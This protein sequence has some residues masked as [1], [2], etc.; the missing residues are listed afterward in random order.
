MFDSIIFETALFN[1]VSNTILFCETLQDLVILREGHGIREERHQ[2]DLLQRIV[3]G[4]DHNLMPAEE[5]TAPS[6]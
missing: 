3:D 2:I 1:E 6:P 5:A 4:F